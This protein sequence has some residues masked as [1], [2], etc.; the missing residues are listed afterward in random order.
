MYNTNLPGVNSKDVSESFCLITTNFFYYNE[1]VI[2]NL[3]RLHVSLFTIC[4]TLTPSDAL[5][6]FYGGGRQQLAWAQRPVGEWR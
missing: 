2:A 1:S 4:C 6:S 3:I 5:A